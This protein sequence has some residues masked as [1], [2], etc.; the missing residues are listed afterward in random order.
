MFIKHKRPISAT[1]SGSDAMYHIFF[2]KCLMHIASGCKTAFLLIRN[3][4]L[5]FS[6]EYF[7]LLRRKKYS[8]F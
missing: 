3:K 7:F 5:Y 6:N 2:Y 8:F 1:P 4:P